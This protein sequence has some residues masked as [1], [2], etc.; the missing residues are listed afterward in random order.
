MNDSSPRHSTAGHR[1]D[2][3]DLAAC[4]QQDPELFFPIGTAGPARD[5]IERARRVCRHC[6]VRTPCLSWAL[7]HGMAAGIWGGA[8]EDERRAMRRAP[9]G[10]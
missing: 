9:A 6:L 1:A 5:Q 8:T 10:R 2:W 4:R 3:R 7:D